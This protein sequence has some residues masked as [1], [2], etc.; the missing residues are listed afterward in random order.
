MNS[1]EPSSRA[2]EDVRQLV[3]ALPARR[4]A[5]SRAVAAAH[6]P[7]RWSSRP[8]KAISHSAKPP[9]SRSMAMPPTKLA[10]MK[11]SEPH[12]RMRP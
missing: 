12:S 9:P 5:P 4:R 1:G 10:M 2:G 8:A 7:R 6:A 3:G 11:V